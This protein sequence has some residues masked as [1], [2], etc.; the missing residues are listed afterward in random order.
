[1]FSLDSFVNLSPGRLVLVVSVRIEFS[2]AVQLVV[3]Y[4]ASSLDEGAP[5][6]DDVCDGGDDGGARG[7]VADLCFGRADSP[8]LFLVPT[9]GGRAK[10]RASLD[11]IN[12]CR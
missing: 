12:H 3:H 4:A 7:G 5:P 11:L 8:Q 9:N 1:M 2:L 6:G 10:C